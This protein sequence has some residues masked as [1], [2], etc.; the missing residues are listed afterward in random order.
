MTLN[1]RE[2]LGRCLTLLRIA[3][4]IEDRLDQI[5]S[6]LGTGTY[7]LTY[8]ASK[9]AVTGQITGSSSKQ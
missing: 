8:T 3:S 5:I 2:A 1:T 6:S 9:L 7:V 4:I